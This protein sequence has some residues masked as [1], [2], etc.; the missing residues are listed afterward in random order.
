MQNVMTFESRVSLPVTGHAWRIAAIMLALLLACSTA[1]IDSADAARK[2][3]K[4]PDVTAPYVKS[5]TTGDSDGDGKLDSVVLVYSETVSVK[6]IKLT[7]SAARA[8]KK[9]LKKKQAKCSKII[10]KRKRAA[11][12]D[13]KKAKCNKIK[14]K[15]KRTACLQKLKP[16]KVEPFSVQGHKVTGVGITDQGKRVQIA[17]EEG[18]APDGG[19]LPTLIYKRVPAGQKGLADKAGN[20]ALGAAMRPKDGVGPVLLGAV[21][22]DTDFNGA[23]DQLRLTFSEPASSATSSNVSVSGYSILSV[24][25]SGGAVVLRLQ[26]VGADSFAQ[27][28]VSVGTPAAADASGNSVINGSVTAVDGAGPVPVDAV[29]VDSNGNGRIDS[30]V[31]TFSESILHAPESGSGASL[32]VAGYL[33]VAAGAASGTTVQISFSEG[34]QYD[35]GSVPAVT[36]SGGGSPVVD[37]SGNPAPASSALV[38]RDGAAPLLVSA[39][40]RD[41]DS[42][43]KLDALRASFSETVSAAGA[44]TAFGVQ[45][46]APVSAP[47]GTITADGANI[48]LPIAEDSGFNTGVPGVGT[49]VTLTYSDPGTG[50][51][52]DLRGLRA[53]SKSVAATDGAGPAVIA[54]TT[55]DVTHN[56]HIDRLTLDL[57]EPVA[58]VIGNPVK[59]AGGARVVTSSTVAGGDLVLALN[60][61]NEDYDGDETPTLDYTGTSSAAVFDAL[62]NQPGTTTTPFVGTTDGAQPIMIAA[63]IQDSRQAGNTPGADGYIDTA[64]STWSE[65][66]VARTTG[67][68]LSLSPALL[69][70][71]DPTA[72]TGNQIEVQLTRGAYPDRDS[73]YNVSYS[74]G[75]PA[76]VVDQA[77]NSA[78]VDGLEMQA[79]PVC[80]DIGDTDT[81]NDVNTATLLTGDE[82]NIL[83]VLC[84]ADPDWVTFTLAPGE[85]SKVAFSSASAVD[86]LPVPK[87]EVW[88]GITDTG[89]DT[90]I[91]DDDGGTP[92]PAASTAIDDGYLIDITDSGAGGTYAIRVSDTA[93]PI[94]DYGYCLTR[95]TG[96]M[97]PVCGVRAGDLIITEVLKDPSSAGTFDRYVELKNASDRTLDLGATGVVGDGVGDLSS[98]RVKYNGGLICEIQRRA[99]T[100][101]TLA[102]GGRIFVASDTAA[103]FFDDL[104]CATGTIPG[105]GGEVSTP[106]GTNMVYTQGFTVALHN[107]QIVDRVNFGQISTVATRSLQLRSKAAFETMTGN[108]DITNGWC[109]SLKSDGSPGIAN[110]NC[111]SVRIDEVAFSP[112]LTGRDGRLFI[113]LHGNGSIKPDSRLLSN[114]RIRVRPDSATDP[115]AAQ[116]FF[117]LPATA[118]PEP[119]G[120]Y[121]LADSPANGD[122]T[123]VSRFSQQVAGLDSVLRGDQPTTVQVLPPVTGGNP[124]NTCDAIP[125]DV[126]SYV[127][128]GGS[129]SFANDLCG[130]LYLVGPFARPVYSADKSASR[131]PNSETSTNNSTDFCLQQL[132]PLDP[133]ISCLLLL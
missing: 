94:A 61:I 13:P 19:D 86:R 118:T 59:V 34:S 46:G 47:S 105:T 95:E 125:V 109:S 123:Y 107:G 69:P 43:G 57:S 130:P 132:S 99:N 92:A 81:R 80:Q 120:L 62:N 73:S 111:D 50:G 21:T 89:A 14:D 100:P 119:T 122:P 98:L 124:V 90:L 11:C 110:G 51:V 126:F 97:V 22:S 18:S 10:D 36:I 83:G 1:A 12:L 42:D 44:A 101:A 75:S 26:E 2:K 48:N 121:V 49:P 113:E 117:Q 127:P 20:Q 25:A 103:A 91:A 6:Q 128:S 4:K 74:G 84:G 38:T 129:F 55:G 35:T 106:F 33:T 96:A 133:A 27:P 9:R 79:A 40:T 16:V 45:G 8:A 7:K 68:G 64:R 88:R 78:Y 58:R 60:E 116:Y 65:P 115:Q 17:V 32:G 66:V 67:A 24:G 70:S 5:S 29:T 56:G 82:N 31:L 41:S 39:S 54:A 102:P 87:F 131:K 53:T 93:A 76:P 85:Q 30:A 108:D 15:K 28:G 77:G 3:K 72:G 23:I 52:A 71:G 37:L 104:G 114:W 112:I 63:S